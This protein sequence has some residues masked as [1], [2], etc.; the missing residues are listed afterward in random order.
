MQFTYK[1]INKDG[2]VITGTAEA[3][4]KQ[5]LIALLHRQNARPMLI[6]AKKK[7][8]MF[9]NLFGPSKKVKSQRPSG[10][11]SPAIDYDFGR[12]AFGAIPV[13]AAG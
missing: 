5:A 4:S 1:A 3:T 10:I 2:K 8:K 12:R 7:N 9:S 11:Y 13:S 6:E